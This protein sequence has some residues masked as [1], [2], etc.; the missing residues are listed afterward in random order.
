MNTAEIGNQ[1]NNSCRLGNIGE[2]RGLRYSLNGALTPLSYRL[3]TGEQAVNETTTHHTYKGRTMIDRNYLQ[4]CAIKNDSEIVRTSM[5]W[6][7]W[8]SGVVDRSQTQN[9]TG[10]DQGT[11]NGI[12]ILYDA[13]GT[14]EDLSQVVFSFELEASGVDLDGTAARAQGAYMVFLN[15]NEIVMSPQGIS[16]NR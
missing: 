1:A 6:N 16:I 2:V 9:N 14:G 4:A 13:F 11:V 3:L 5:A 12:G 8:N 10:C 7:N 15:K